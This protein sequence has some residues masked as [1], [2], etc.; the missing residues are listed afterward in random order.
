M[1][2]PPP[3]H[4]RGLP[5]QSPPSYQSILIRGNFLLVFLLPVI[6]NP[7]ADMQADLYKSKETGDNRDRVLHKTDKH[8]N[9]WPQYLL[10]QSQGHLLLCLISWFLPPPKSPLFSHTPAHS[11]P[12]IPTVSCTE[13]SM[14]CGDTVEIWQSVE[15]IEVP[16]TETL[17]SLSHL[18]FPLSVVIP[19][20][21]LS[22]HQP[23]WFQASLPLFLDSTIGV[24]EDQGIEKKEKVNV[25]CLRHL[26]IWDTGPNTCLTGFRD[27]FSGR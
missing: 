2:W 21:C 9:P 17:S 12:N 19:W 6:S 20:H 18:L 8:P 11:Y 24:W 14:G 15:N 3:T 4:P 7:A 5:R 23:L 22:S 25:E 27:P 26:T 10:C 16:S 13:I 1:H